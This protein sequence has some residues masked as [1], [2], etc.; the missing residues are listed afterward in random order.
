MV[1]N[2]AGTLTCGASEAMALRLTPEA[3]GAGL[4]SWAVRKKQIPGRGNGKCRGK[5]A[6]ASCCGEEHP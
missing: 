6:R 5:G 4:P 2:T 1:G 3:E